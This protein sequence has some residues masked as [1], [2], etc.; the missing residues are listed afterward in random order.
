MADPKKVETFI[1]AT[2]RGVK[3]PELFTKDDETSDTVF[4]SDK[5]QWKVRYWLDAAPLNW[6]SFY[7]NDV[8]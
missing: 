8:A 5:I 6:R 4:A 7:R 3:E 2:L 1:I